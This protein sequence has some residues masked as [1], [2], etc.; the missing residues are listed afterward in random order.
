M[1]LS[2]I[3]SSSQ[4][5][6]SFILKE[7][8]M[9]REGS[10]QGYLTETTATS[11]VKAVSFL[12]PRQAAMNKLWLEMWINLELHIREWWR[13]SSMVLTKLQPFQR[14]CNQMYSRTY[15]KT[16]NTLF[17]LLKHKMY[18]KGSY[19]LFIT[20]SQIMMILKPDKKCTQI[21]SLNV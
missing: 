18:L 20:F 7:G 12:Q 11:F 1:L 21:P 6:L 3:H 14:I 9:L 17:S 2:S 4:K 5:G 15:T 10:E 16:T 8:I 19:F 13:A